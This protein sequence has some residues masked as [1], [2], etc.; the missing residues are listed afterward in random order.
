MRLQLGWA[1]GDEGNLLLSQPLFLPRVSLAGSLNQQV[2]WK[3]SGLSSDGHITQLPLASA[4]SILQ[5]LDL[6]SVSAV[7]QPSLKPGRAQFAV[8]WSLIWCEEKDYTRI[9]HQDL[10]HASEHTC[11]SGR[12]AYLCTRPWQPIQGL[13]GC[14]Q[15]SLLAEPLVV[16][17]VIRRLSSPGQWHMIFP[18]LHDRRYAESAGGSGTACAADVRGLQR[19][20]A[21]PMQP[22]SPVCLCP[23]QADLPGHRH[24][25]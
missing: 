10:A 15:A 5:H 22:A 24:R 1:A 2:L 18:K 16:A 12:T 8:L 23:W 4:L 6:A 7:L 11:M 13:Q 14:L 19:C 25:P 9:Q 20:W 3:H 17:L 21:L